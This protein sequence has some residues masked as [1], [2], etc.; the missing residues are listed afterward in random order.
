MLHELDAA[1]FDPEELKVAVMGATLAMRACGEGDDA[2]VRLPFSRPRGFR[3]L[4]EFGD[5]SLCLSCAGVATDISMP[6]RCSRERSARR[7]SFCW[8][9]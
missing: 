6:S 8:R 9:V 7:M 5:L 1:P 3:F 4:F 2:K